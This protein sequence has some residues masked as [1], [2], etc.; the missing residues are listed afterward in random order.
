MIIRTAKIEDSRGIAQVVV[1]TWRSTYQGIIPEDFL[2]SMS[3]QQAADNFS[4]KI[5]AGAEII[6]VVENQ[7][8]KIIGFAAGGRADGQIVTG[9]IYAIYILKEYQKAGIGRRLIRK[10]ISILL[11][12]GINSM[13][14]WALADNPARHFYQALGGIEAKEKY[15]YTGGRKLKEIGYYWSDLRVVIDHI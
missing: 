13:I 9:E 3:Y 14:I 10:F 15:D 6:L 12:R 11:E 4:T 1:D 5:K 7:I 8:G 2:K